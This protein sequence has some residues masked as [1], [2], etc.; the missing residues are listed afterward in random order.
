MYRSSGYRT[1][2]YWPRYYRYRDGDRRYYRYRDYDRR[3]YRY[4]DDDDRYDRYRDS[5][6]RHRGDGDDQ[7]EDNDDQ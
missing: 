4:R 5:W 7:G 2:G 6:R 3:Y 1:Y